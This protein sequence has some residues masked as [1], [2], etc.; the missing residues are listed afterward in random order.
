MKRILAI[1]LYCSIGVSVSLRGQSN[2]I[3][4]T[5]ASSWDAIIAEARAENKL[6]FVDCYA[7]W[8]GPCKM[9]DE[10]IYSQKAGGDYF[11]SRFINVKLQMDQSPKDNEQTRSFYKVAERF[12]RQYA[13]TAFPT[14]LFFSPEGVPV[15]KFTGAS[16]EA[17]E[18]I[19][20]AES[21]LDPNQQ[22]FTL[23]SQLPFHNGDSAF[24]L[25]AI[26]AA[27]NAGDEMSAKILANEYIGFLKKPISRPMIELVTPYISSES[28]KGFNCFVQNAAMIN[29]E[30]EKGF[31]EATVS[32]VIFKEEITP[33]L[34]INGLVIKWKDIVARME[35]KY[36]SLDKNLFSAQIESQ[37][38]SAIG[39]LIAKEVADK[40]V[41]Q[42]EWKEVFE[43]FQKRFPGYDFGQI[44][45]TI[46][47]RYFFVQKSWDNCSEATILLLDGYSKQIGAGTVNNMIWGNIFLHDSNKRRL[48]K[49][50]KYMYDVI[51]S[52]PDDS[53]SLDTYANL[54]YKSGNKKDAIE[55]E[56]KAISVAQK[57]GIY[58]EDLMAALK[59]MQEGSI[60]W[61]Q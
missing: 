34:S 58:A 33:V 21:A 38:K 57:K 28:D 14:F 3:A 30:E 17:G 12:S 20:R 54:L 50:K 46:K 37:F 39:K 25:H 15:H 59:K 9:M 24:L 19:K 53:Y 4:F 5:S 23:L 1:W 41:S 45:L 26:T 8:C 29:Q 2:G 6:I 44:F 27:N 7:T 49:A 48:E 61:E 42:H 52:S 13:I 56:N 18:F 22:Y 32:P 16:E 36:P 55:W 31:A 10:K 11:N 40:Q 60:T 47:M 51:R 35:T 43:K